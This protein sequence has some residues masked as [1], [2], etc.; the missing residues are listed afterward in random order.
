MTFDE[1]LEQVLEMLQRRGRVSYRALKR[2]FD[3]DDAYLADLKAEII[4]VHRFA[5][6]QDGTILVWTGEP[7]TTPAIDQEYRPVSSTAPR[8]GPP[9]APETAAPQDQP[10]DQSASVAP[11]EAAPETP[12]AE[13]R[14]L[15]VLF[16]DLVDSTALSR[17]LD[18][19]DYRE[20][21]R[22]YQA[23]CAA[24]IQRFDGHIAQYLG[25]GLLVYFGYPLA[26]EDDAQRAVRAGLGAIDAVGGLHPHL[27]QQYG[28]RLAVRVG[29]HTG[30]VVVGEVGAGGRREQLALGETPNIAARLQSLTAPNTVAI[31][32][33]SQ[34][35]VQGYFV[36]HALDV[37]TLKGV[38]TPLQVYQV[39][40]ESAAQSRL[41]MA[42]P[43]GLTPMAAGPAHSSPRAADGGLRLVHRGV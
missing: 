9:R 35:L 17:R 38:D 2:Q 39:V 11:P 30:L 40:E 18:P 33:A 27:A 21:V 37:Q 19:E 24:V 42:S 34:H 10:A 29:V 25:D 41:D 43:R 23:A 22:A 1:I 14:Q 4:D 36:C 12:D 32:A 8:P 5:M 16:C 28:V 3:L 7:S 6:D 26:H 20:V 13:R 15:T 31:S